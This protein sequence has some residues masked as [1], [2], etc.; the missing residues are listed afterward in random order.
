[1]CPVRGAKHDFGKCP[2][3]DFFK[4]I[5]CFACFALLALL[6]LLC[7]ACLLALLSDA[8]KRLAN[9]TRKQNLVF[10]TIVPY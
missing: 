9:A 10:F 7:F 5:L 6:A 3:L 1:M 4:D 2:N 8:N